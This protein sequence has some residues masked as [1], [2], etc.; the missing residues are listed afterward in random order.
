MSRTNLSGSGRLHD[1]SVR[2]IKII[3]IVIVLALLLPLPR[4]IFQ[5]MERSNYE[6]PSGT[7]STTFRNVSFLLFLLNH[8]INPLAVVML[9]D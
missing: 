3:L 9:S 5:S 7:V 1:S 4:F 8:S 2:M 6:F